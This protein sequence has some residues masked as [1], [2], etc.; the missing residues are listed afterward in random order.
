MALCAISSILT[1]IVLNLHHHDED[2]KIPHRVHVVFL[3]WLPKILC[4]NVSDNKKEID[5]ERAPNKD[6]LSQITSEKKREAETVD[7]FE[8]LKTI[9]REM[10]IIK[11]FFGKPMKVNNDWRVLA[12]VVDRLFFWICL[13]ACS[14]GSFVVLAKRDLEY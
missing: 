8:Y 5:I 6:I 1:I 9:E 2:K 14:V 3:K 10:Q 11:S 12:L 7:V 13:I 4:I